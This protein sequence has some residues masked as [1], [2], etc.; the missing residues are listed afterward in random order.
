MMLMDREDGLVW[1]GMIDVEGG[2][3]IVF[4]VKFEDKIVLCLG[5]GRLN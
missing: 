4:W 1:L 2:F 5:D 3:S